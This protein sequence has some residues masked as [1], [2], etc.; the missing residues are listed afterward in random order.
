MIRGRKTQK[1]PPGFPIS[2][3]K[4]ET[5]FAMDLLLHLIR[6][7]RMAEDN[8]LN[9]FQELLMGKRFE[10]RRRAGSIRGMIFLITPVAQPPGDLDGEARA[11]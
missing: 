11:R 8:D 6:E 3:I 1:R 7:V 5:F 10:G 2:Y 4:I 9:P